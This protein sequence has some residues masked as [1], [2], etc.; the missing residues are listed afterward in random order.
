[1]RIVALLSVLRI[2]DFRRSNDSSV[3]RIQ[4]IW[5]SRKSKERQ[6]VPLIRFPASWSNMTKTVPYCLCQGPP[7]ILF[8]VGI[9][10]TVDIQ[11]SNF[12]RKNIVPSLC[13]G[14]VRADI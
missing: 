9:S 8:F 11:A 2:S 3:F 5:G 10:K 13:P 12:A 4:K 1:M 14:H 6:K 7:Q